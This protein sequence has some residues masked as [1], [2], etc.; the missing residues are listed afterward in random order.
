MTL[1]LKTRK[2][3]N[4]LHHVLIASGQTILQKSVGAV[5]MLLIDPND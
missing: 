1:P 5:P 3:L 4:R 2:D